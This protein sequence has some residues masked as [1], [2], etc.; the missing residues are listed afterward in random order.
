M[1]DA[2][3]E[4][5]REF[6]Q[7]G[8]P[9]GIVHRDV[10]C[11]ENLSAATVLKGMRRTG[12]TFVTYERM[13]SLIA[14]GIAPGRIVH[15]NFEDDRIKRLRLDELQLINEVHAE[16]YPEHAREK[17]WFFLDELQ[18]VEGWE[19]YARR[20][21]DSPKVVLCLTGSSS[22]LLS[23]E[24][25]TAMR[26]RAV[27]IEVF[28]LSFR[29]F[30][31]FN[32]ILERIPDQGFTALER[33]ILRNA[34]TRYLAVGGFPAVQGMPDSLRIATLQEYVQ[35]VLFRDVLQRHKV[36]SVQSL[37]YT[38]DYLLH[39]Y[40]RRTSAHTISGVLKNLA[41]PCRREDIADY[42]S[43]FKDAYLFH[44]VS[45]MSDSLAVKRVNPDKYYVIDT[46]LVNAVSPKR[47]AENGWKLENLVFMS[48]RRG[49]NKIFYCPLEQ[50]REVDFCVQDMLTGKTS[51]IQVAWSMVE[52]ETFKRELTALRDARKATG[53]DDCVIVTW[54]DEGLLDDGI[55]IV[56]AWK[57]CLERDVLDG[58]MTSD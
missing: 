43:F 49:R 12:K 28:P 9:T 45:V 19:A 33:G 38:L 6:Y 27:P 31:R 57:W 17:C 1:K 24:I 52:A 30:I 7:D 11:Y 48:L 46:G 42:L 23:E 39:N 16:L 54:E 4:V 25:A 35:A 14:S 53:I 2:I 20:L 3:R 15:L 18:T 34:M 36:V 41:L 40:A 5:L 58:A 47:D 13:S 29:E 51:L 8:L 22:K 10:P 55:R 50:N 21:V 44:P 26:G 56:P 32:G 37:Q